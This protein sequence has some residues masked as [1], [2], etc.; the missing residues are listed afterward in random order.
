MLNQSD[1]TK[2]ILIEIKPMLIKSPIAI[3]T[4]GPIKKHD[5][6]QKLWSHLKSVSDYTFDAIIYLKKQPK[7][8]K[9]RVTEQWI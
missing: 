6:F 3:V 1:V 7:P 8:C 4:Y 5:K 2:I 9:I